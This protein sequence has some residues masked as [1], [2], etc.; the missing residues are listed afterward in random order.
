[1]ICNKSWQG[2][3]VSGR[4]TALVL[5]GVSVLMWL[6]G[7]FFDAPVNDI[8]LFGL[9]TGNVV[10]RCITFACFALAAAMMS[11]WYVFDRRIRWFLSMFF[12]LASVSLFVHGCVGYAVSLL[13]LLLVIHRLFSC[14][15]EEDCRYGLFSAFALFGL[16]TM[17]FPQFIMLLPVFVGYM[18]MTSLARHKEMFSILLGLLTPYWFLFG[19]DFIFP[20]VLQQGNLFIAPFKY[21]ASVVFTVPT[22]SVLP[23]AVFELLVLIPFVFMFSA[24][25]TPGKPLLRK[26]LRFFAWTNFY[27]VLLSVLYS[28]DFALYYIW[29]LPAMAV[30]LTYIFTLKIT[31]FSR[32]YFIAMAILL[33]AMIPFSLCLKAL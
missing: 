8:S 26:R 18:I 13:F 16:A 33:F 21:V 6:V 32:F 27:L 17:L 10:S 5:I 15:Q 4:A 30:M 9:K 7:I 22:L 25:A 29:S 31:R 2:R 12:Y 1:M 11:S 24:S 14:K 28:H 3:F 19:I 20:D 23:V